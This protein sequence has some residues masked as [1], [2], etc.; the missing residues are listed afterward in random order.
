[1]GALFSKD[2]W[3]NSGIQVGGKYTVQCIREGGKHKG[4]L[5][6]ANRGKVL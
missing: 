5:A 4:I 2:V 1:M 3:G 6:A